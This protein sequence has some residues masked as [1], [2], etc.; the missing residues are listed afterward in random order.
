MSKQGLPRRL[1]LAASLGALLIGGMTWLCHNLVVDDG[2][3]RMTNFRD[4]ARQSGLAFRMSFLATEQGEFFKTNFYDHGCGVVVGDFDGDGFDDVYFLNQAGPNALFRNKGDGTFQ[5]ITHQ[6]RV[7]LGD[8]VCVVATF[9]D[10]DNSGRQSLYVT[11]TRGGNVL[12][13]NMGDGTFKD[14]TAKAGLTHIGHSQTAVFFDYD[15]DGYLNLFVTNSAQ[16]TTNTR[17]PDGRHYLGPTRLDELIRSSK[18]QNILYHNNR[19]GTFTNV[20]ARSGLAGKGWGG[21][22]AVFDYNGDGF[23]DLL[24]TSMFGVTQLY[25]N[26]GDG[27]FSDVTKGVL[28]RTTFGAIGCKPFDFNNDG[29]LNL[30]IVDMH[31]DMWLPP[32]LDPRTVPADTLPNSPPSRTKLYEQRHQQRHGPPLDG[33][34]AVPFRGRGLR[35]HPVPEV[36][37]GSICRGFRPG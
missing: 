8:R 5:D 4:A 6:A 29:L 21:D 25:Q 26:N 28:G 24:V 34:F 36:A 14:V 37:I 17:S 23:L 32:T 15:N 2:S 7:A 1:I 33:C 18:E 9:A 31:S 22:V 30:L 19:D 35:Q 11:S 10:Y 3:S 20:T 13:R 16:W 27:T 12:F